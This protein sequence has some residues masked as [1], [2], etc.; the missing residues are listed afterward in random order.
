M[1]RQ[2]CL[3]VQSVGCHA[4]LLLHLRLQVLQTE[5]MHAE[6]QGHHAVTWDPGA[7]QLIQYP[8]Q[9][10]LACGQPSCT[11]LA[12]LSLAEVPGNVKEDMVAVEDHAHLV[13]MVVSLSGT[14]DY[15]GGLCR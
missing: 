11:F 4:R 9:P 3:S 7:Q 15:P 10:G 12:S 5:F 13:Q 1:G 2:C 8:W 6:A 14:L